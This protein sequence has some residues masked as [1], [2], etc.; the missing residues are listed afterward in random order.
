[1]NCKNL[2]KIV[3]S[4]TDNPTAQ[5]FW[6]TLYIPADTAAIQTI[7]MVVVMNTKS[8]TGFRKNRNWFS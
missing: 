4:V 7:R 2:T 6:D 8:G 5:L 3:S 1:M